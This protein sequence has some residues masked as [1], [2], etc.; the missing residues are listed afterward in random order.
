LSHFDSEARAALSGPFL[1]KKGKGYSGHSDQHGHVA[2]NCG[3][4]GVAQAKAQLSEVIERAMTEGPQEITKGGK[5]A[6]MV[7]SKKEW[8]RKPASALPEMPDGRKRSTAD[9]WL[10]SP[11]RRSGINLEPLNAKMR[12]VE[13]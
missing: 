12:E 7:V 6:M 9:F 4:W 10:Y 13:F 2:G 11:L 1:C 8:L 3:T 5:D